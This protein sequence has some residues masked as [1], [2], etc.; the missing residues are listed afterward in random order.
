VKKPITFPIM[1]FEPLQTFRQEIHELLTKAK[2]A[3]FELMDAVMTTRHASSLAE[4]SLSPMFRR[5]YPSTYEALED[6]RP[7]RNQLMKL[8]K[9]R[10]KNVSLSETQ[11]Q[12]NSG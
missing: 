10:T 2:D 5:R 11:F 9:Y 4:F 8:P 1:N 6:A 3:T 12:R 7:Q